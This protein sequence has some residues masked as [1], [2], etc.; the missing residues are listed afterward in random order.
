MERFIDLNYFVFIL[1]NIYEN[2]TILKHTNFK[3]Y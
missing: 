1:D 3:Q 2:F